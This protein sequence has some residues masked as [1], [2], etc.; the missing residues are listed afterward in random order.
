MLNK[1]V[2]ETKNQSTVKTNHMKVKKVPKK[3]PAMKMDL[4]SGAKKLKLIKDITQK[5]T[6]VLIISICIYESISEINFDWQS[7]KI[8]SKFWLKKLFASA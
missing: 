7:A 1:A 2:S 4:I 6:H 3:I 5:Q 8:F